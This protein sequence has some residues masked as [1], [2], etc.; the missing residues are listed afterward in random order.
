LE[1]SVKTLI[2]VSWL[3]GYASG[4]Y[5]VL[6]PFYLDSVGA[7]FVEMG[8]VFTVSAMVMA[9]VNILIGAQ[10]DVR[11]RKLFYSASLA[12]GSVV[13]FL[14]PL[15]N[16]LWQMILLRMGQ[17]TSAS[18]R[19]SVHTVLLFEQAR[20]RFLTAY[21]RVNGLEYSSQAL[22]LLGGGLIL[23]AASFQPAFW[24]SGTVLAIAL[25]IFT[26]GV[27][28][29][30]VSVGRRVRSGSSSLRR[31]LKI[32]AVSGFVVS[33]GF[34][35]SHG[36]I[37][38]IFFAKKF[39]ADKAAVSLILTV[40]RLSFGVPLIFAD[41]VIGLLKR[42]S[43]KTILIALMIYQGAAI[44]LTAFIPDILPATAVFVTHDLLGAAYWVPVQ[45]ALI[46]SYCREE[47]RGEDSSKVGSVSA[48]GAIAAPF[49]AG[50]LASLNISYPF[51]V[52]GIITAAGA[53]ILILI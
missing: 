44:S 40:H 14:V 34:G 15:F 17:D 10:S 42:F 36:F 27:K 23:A 13:N 8:I 3:F 38:P 43:M 20:K 24:V 30:P 49:L 48:V 12:L 5:E 50:F 9:F 26:I 1:R 19:G 31:E 16:N 39:S 47:A 51:L 29:E 18:V 2:L 46:Q 53:L 11:G 41:K 21:S 28:E 37:T 4:A 22:G 7:S 6:F 32:L 25:L 52:S 45:S 35:C 33:V